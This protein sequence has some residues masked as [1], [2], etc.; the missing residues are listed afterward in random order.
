M[1]DGEESVKWEYKI[2]IVPDQINPESMTN[3][4]LQAGDEGWEAVS[5]TPKYGSPAY[6]ALLKRQRDAQ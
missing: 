3:G 5:L 6:I 4:L 1:L 2:M